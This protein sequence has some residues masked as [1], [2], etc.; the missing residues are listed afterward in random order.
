MNLHI[1]PSIINTHDLSTLW[2]YAKGAQFTYFNLESGNEHYRLLYHI[3]WQIP[4][5]STIIDIGTSTGH[6]ALALSAN[7]NI[8]VI[9][10]NICDQVQ[11][12]GS[13]KQKKNI[14]IRI[15]NCIDDIGILLQSPFIM[16]DVFHDGT[17]EKLL[18]ETLLKHN[19]NGIVL[20]DDI[21]LNKEMLDFWNWV[22]VSKMDITEYGHWSG[23][24]LLLFGNSTT[25]ILS[26]TIKPIAP[27][28][29]GKH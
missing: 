14:N 13:I 28:Y 5:N 6:S 23:T 20:C 1:I 4:N 18:V 7:P 16:L 21:F 8:N 17:F 2:P 11:D 15:K 19:Y 10:Y 22:P 26:N 3:S 9:T 29:N 25:T 27:F 12:S 24:G